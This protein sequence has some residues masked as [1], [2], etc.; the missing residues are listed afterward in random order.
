LAF[1]Q[2]FFAA[3]PVRKSIRSNVTVRFATSI[4]VR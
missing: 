3:S 4:F 2:A 1:F